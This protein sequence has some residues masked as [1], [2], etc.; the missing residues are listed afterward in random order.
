[1]TRTPT[2]TPE[3]NPVTATP[4][5]PDSLHARFHAAAELHG[6]RPAVSD[7]QGTTSY[8]ELAEQSRA[9]AEHLAP[10]TGTGQLVALRA[11]R[12]RHALAGILGI[13]GTG[14]GYLPVDPGYPQARQDHLLEDSGTALVLSNCGLL[15][16]EVGIGTVAGFELAERPAADR[17]TTGR[18]RP[19]GRV[20]EGTAY[21]IYT[22]GSTGVPKGCLVGHRQVLAL[23]DATLPLFG[24]GPEDVWSLFHSWSFDF[25]VWE[26]W[27]ALLGGGHAL[28]VDR[29]TAADP[30]AFGELLRD[31]GVTVLSQVP[32]AFGQLVAELTATGAL[33]PELRQVVFGGEAVIPQD[34][35]RWWQAGT[36]PAARLVNMYGITET[37]VHVSYCPLTPGT[38]DGSAAGRTPIGVPLPHLRVSLRDEEGRPVPVGTPGEM[39]VAG[40]GVCDGYLGRPELTAQRFVRD[41]AGPADSPDRHYRSGDWAVADADGSLFYAGRQDGQVKLR[42][43]RIELG[44][45]EAALRSAPGVTAAG[46]LLDG[47]DDEQH[48]TLTACVV[49]GTEP[50]S[51]AALRSH[52]AGLLPAHMLPQRIR[53]V[54]RLPLTA[55]GK[56]DRRALATAAA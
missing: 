33:L 19:T 1:M 40:A 38:L 18:G 13:L 34:L 37:T 39:W 16:G 14:A 22:S 9:L 31:R 44:E 45:I 49:T 41:P 50:A 17:P 2:P 52:L 55:H 48:R 42:G 11:D 7:L 15:P 43:F 46:C 28:V 36:A 21:T 4:P 56:L 26:I 30:E 23:M 3:D 24:T 32:S 29:A 51:P 10:H 6:D 8:R 27:G 35:R 5:V 47:G 12:S 25:S 54:D 53:F 20:P